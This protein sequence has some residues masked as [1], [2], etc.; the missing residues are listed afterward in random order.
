[1]KNMKTYAEVLNEGIEQID[2]DSRLLAAVSP[3]WYEDLDGVTDL[4]DR[5]ANVNARNTVDE[6]PLHWAARNGHANLA[7]LLLDRGAQVDALTNAGRTPLHLAALKGYTDVARVLLDKGAVVDYTGDTYK[8][9]LQIAVDW[10]KRDTIM[11]LL[12]RGA[13]PLKAFKGPA[14][15]LDFF[16]GDIDAVPEPLKTKIKRM[17]RGKSAF[18]M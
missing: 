14:E 10:D 15:I 16:K 17:Q 18:G 13:D 11:L 9:P 2:L 1:M 5:G 7:R 12:Q 3:L 6:T 8:T 4:L